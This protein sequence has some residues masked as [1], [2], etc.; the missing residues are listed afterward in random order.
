MALTDTHNWS[1]DHKLAHMALAPFR[2]LGRG[3]QRIWENDPRY[4]RVQALSA[5][6]NEQLIERGTTREAMLRKV[7]LP[8]FHQ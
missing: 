5:L 3:M 8:Y 4:K 7:F 6:S 1:Q 2:A